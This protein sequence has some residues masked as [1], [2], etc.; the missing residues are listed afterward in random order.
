AFASDDQKIFQFPHTIVWLATA[1]APIAP[2]EG[3]HAAP[4]FCCAGLSIGGGSNSIANQNSSHPSFT[5]DGR[6]VAFLT[7]A[8]NF[9][10]NVPAGVT[11][12][13]LRGVSGPTLLLSRTSTG[14][15][16]R[17]VGAIAA[18]G[19]VTNLSTLA[20]AR[21]AFTT[22]ATNLGGHGLQTYVS[23]VAVGA[24]RVI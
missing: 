16:D 18:G 24:P 15:S 7:S 20:G 13:Y 8:T 10:F 21:V 12:A 23:D 17:D 9:G 5:G 14:A 11:Q 22:A 2:V 4:F 19:T 6:A 1:V 3:V